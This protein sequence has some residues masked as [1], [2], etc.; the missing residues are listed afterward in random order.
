MSHIVPGVVTCP[1]CSA[2]WTA[3]LFSAIDADTIP[4]QVD[5]ILD[6]V[7]ERQTCNQC[8]RVFRP[9]HRMLFASHSWKLWVVMYPLT[10]CRDYEALEP[11][12]MDLIDRHLAGAA[13]GVQERLRELR[14]RLVFG[15]HMLTE[16]VRVAYAGIDPAMLE[17]AKLFAMRDNV[18]LLLQHGPYELCFER[19]DDANVMVCGIHA[20][21]GGERVGELP[22]PETLFAEAAAMS[23]QLIEQ[24]PELLDGAYVSATR[25]LVGPTL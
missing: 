9:D 1:G 20:L 22:L 2:S 19:M 24:Y 14:P 10:D 15:Q 17:C 7:F 21:P 12:V 11:A 13:P 23:E 3:G 6:G 16:A 25:Y 4:V 18:A 5:A 8:A